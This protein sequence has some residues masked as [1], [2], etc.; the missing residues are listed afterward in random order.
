MAIRE[1]EEARKVLRRRC[2]CERIPV[3]REFSRWPPVVAGASRERRSERLWMLLKATPDVPPASHFRRGERPHPSV[4]HRMFA[5]AR[6]LN[7]AAGGVKADRSSD[8][9]DQAQSGRFETLA[10]A[11]RNAPITARGPAAK[12]ADRKR[13]RSASENRRKFHSPIERFARD[14]FA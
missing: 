5:N 9:P 8:S 7:V 10:S 4:R 12:H 6:R 1:T 2:R 3:V 11:N 13:L 14:G